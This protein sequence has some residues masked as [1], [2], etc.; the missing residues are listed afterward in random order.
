STLDLTLSKLLKGII[1]DCKRGIIDILDISILLYSLKFVPFTNEDKG[2]KLQEEL[3]ECITNQL[4]STS[5]NWNAKQFIR[6]IQQLQDLIL[7]DY[8]I[9]GSL[10]L[11]NNRDITWDLDISFIQHKGIMKLYCWRD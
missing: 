7:W 4:Y 1:K 6:K 10:V 5:A 2:M 11:Y 8:S 3:T 9:N